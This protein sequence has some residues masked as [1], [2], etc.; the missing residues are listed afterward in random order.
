M[1]NVGRDVGAQLAQEDREQR[2]GADAIHVEVAVERDA[3]PGADP[4]ADAKHRRAKPFEKKRIRK[5][6][7][8][9]SEKGSGGF[10]ARI[11]A[12]REDSSGERV[13]T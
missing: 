6:P 11:A 9:V 7:E 10:G 2:G 13:K 5:I 3:L 4:I 12:V 8:P 1:G